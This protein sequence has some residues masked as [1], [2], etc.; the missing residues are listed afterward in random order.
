[1]RALLAIAALAFPE[2]SPRNPPELEAQIEAV[3]KVMA[4][5]GVVDQVVLA[6]CGEVN[7]YYWPDTKTVT[8]CAEALALPAWR[9]V[10]AHEL[11][12]ADI[13]QLDVSYTG[14][15]EAAADELSWVRLIE[16]GRQGDVLALARFYLTL[17]SNYEPSPVDDHPESHRRAYT[18]MCLVFGAANPDTTCGKRYKHAKAVWDK[19]VP[20]G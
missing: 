14:S 18:A 17:D 2:P 10:V 3:G 12:H 9:A 5:P 13:L 19:L 15:G 6:Q 16:A 11:A 1:M 7:A 8:L 4:T 20:R